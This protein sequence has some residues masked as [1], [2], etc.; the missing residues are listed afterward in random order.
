MITD[1]TKQS[2]SNENRVSI[3]QD[4][5]LHV[6]LGGL[7]HSDPTPD[8][9]QIIKYVFRL[10]TADGEPFVHMVGDTAIQVLLT[11]LPIVLEANPKSGIITPIR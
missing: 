3:D 8:G 9:K 4:T 2:V 5:I 11:S 7:L 6:K 1:L 10:C